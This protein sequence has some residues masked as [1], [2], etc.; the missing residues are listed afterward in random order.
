MTIVA[1]SGSSGLVGSALIPSLRARG[2]EVRRL[3]RIGA[4]APDAIAWNPK[5]GAIDEARCQGIEA[6]IHLA[7]EN[8]AAKRWTK[9]RRDVLEDRKSTRLN[10]SHSSVSRMP[11]SA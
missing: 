4:E 6:V 2:H 10:S 9:A 5:T 1:V 11:S 8:I 7:G 3:V